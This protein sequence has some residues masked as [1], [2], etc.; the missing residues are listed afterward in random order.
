MAARD[1]IHS[2]LLRLKE[3]TPKQLAETCGISL[4][5]VYIALRA[6]EAEAKATRRT[7]RPEPFTRQD[8]WSAL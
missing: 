6:L 4:N 7:A 3:Q 2:T 1:E 5:R 8:Y